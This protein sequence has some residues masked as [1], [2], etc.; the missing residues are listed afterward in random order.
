MAIFKSW[1]SFALIF[2]SA[3]AISHLVADHVSS[4]MTQ[5]GTEQLYAAVH[6]R[7]PETGFKLENA[8]PAPQWNTSPSQPSECIR[9]AKEKHRDSCGWSLCKRILRG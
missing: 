8:S 3:A 4:H 1:T 5:Q 9:T 2:L 7:L 6:T